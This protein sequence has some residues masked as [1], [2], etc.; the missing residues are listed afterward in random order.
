VGF[1]VDEVTVGQVFFE[2]F[3]FPCYF[4]FH[5][6]PH[7]HLPTGAGSINQIVADVP[8]GLNLTLHDKIKKE[9]LYADGV[10]A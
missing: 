2:Y 3:A 4:P 10:M 6:M 5:Q 8:S 7:A 1:V 9:K